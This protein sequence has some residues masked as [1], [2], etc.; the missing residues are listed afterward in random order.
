MNSLI[1]C[2]IKHKHGYVHFRF[3]IAC[4]YAKIELVIKKL[5]IGQIFFLLFDERKNNL[6]KIVMSLST[7]SFVHCG[8]G[9]DKC[10][11]QGPFVHLTQ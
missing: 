11:P 7:A 2:K 10:S 6:I 8:T 3:W 9:T 4:V 1:E 5:M